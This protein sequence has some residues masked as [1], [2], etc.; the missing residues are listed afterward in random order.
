MGA[1]AVGE[2]FECDVEL[3]P[4]LRLEVRLVDT[5]VLDGVELG[6]PPM[7]VQLRWMPLL[8]LFGRV[9]REAAR[10]AGDVFGAWEASV[11]AEARKQ[12]GS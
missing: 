5:G 8:Q 7:P 10:A 9:Q 12:V 3:V 1:T 6:G 4:G 11:R 2:K